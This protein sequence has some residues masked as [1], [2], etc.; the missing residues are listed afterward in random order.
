MN[1][2][3]D[4]AARVALLPFSRMVAVLL[5]RY[6]YCGLSHADAEDCAAEAFLEALTHWDSFEPQRGS[7]EVWVTAIALNVA[8]RR[9]A[10]RA[11]ENLA[12]EAIAAASKKPRAPSDPNPPADDASSHQS[13][14]PN[15]AKIA[16]LNAALDKRSPVEQAIARDRRETGWTKR[17]AQKFGISEDNVRVIWFRLKKFLE[18]ML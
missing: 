13:K 18:G 9:F 10:N 5:K 6:G 8:R 2:K 15:A 4:I 3:S 7:L 1:D 17:I 16:A 12:L 14:T 11:K